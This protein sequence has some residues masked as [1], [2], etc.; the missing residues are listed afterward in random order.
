MATLSN[1]LSGPVSGSK[2]S[3]NVHTDKI[4]FAY[5]AADMND[6]IEITVL[7]LS[8]D[9]KRGKLGVK[10]NA[11]AFAGIAKLAKAGL[12]TTKDLARY[13]HEY[14]GAI[15]GFQ[16]YDDG[17][18]A[19]CDQ[20]DDTASEIYWEVNYQA[21]GNRITITYKAGLVSYTVDCVVNPPNS[22][23]GVDYNISIFLLAYSGSAN[24]VVRKVVAPSD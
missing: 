14:N 7:K 22:T 19:L 15:H 21:A 24:I 5:N 1:I 23:I 6:L 16:F 11:N 13:G 10:V 4:R 2:Y 8:E 9:R 3:A 12:Y 17:T 18:I 20:S